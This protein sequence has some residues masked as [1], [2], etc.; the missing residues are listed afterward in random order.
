MN[1]TPNPE[2]VCLSGQLAGRM[3]EAVDTLPMEGAGPATRELE[4]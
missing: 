2:P 4:P 1:H 3:G